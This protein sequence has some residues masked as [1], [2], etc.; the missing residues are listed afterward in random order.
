LGLTALGVAILLFLVQV[1]VSIGLIMLFESPW[2][3]LLSTFYI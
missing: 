3:K 2:T 1:G